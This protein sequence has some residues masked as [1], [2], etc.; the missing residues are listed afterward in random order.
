MH[1]ISPS[2]LYNFFYVTN[3]FSFCFSYTTNEF[4]SDY[5]PTVFDNFASIINVDGQDVK[6]DLWDTAGM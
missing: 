3:F 5:I 2:K 4:P 6:L 1:Y